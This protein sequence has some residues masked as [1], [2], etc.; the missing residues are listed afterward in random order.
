MPLLIKKPKE[1]EMDFNQVPLKANQNRKLKRNV[2][3][4]ID[5]ALEKPKKPKKPI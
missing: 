1:K 5:K 3:W 2:P 4:H